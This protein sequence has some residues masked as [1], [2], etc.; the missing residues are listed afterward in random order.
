MGLKICNKNKDDE[1]NTKD[2][3]LNW[4]WKNIFFKC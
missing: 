4:S 2:F 3:I 1:L